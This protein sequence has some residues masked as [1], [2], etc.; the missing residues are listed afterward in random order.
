MASLPVFPTPPAP[1]IT[2]E[3]F[4][5]QA[6]PSGSLFPDLNLPPS[7][8]DRFLSDWKSSL[9]GL[10][11]S[12]AKLKLLLR[13]VSGFLSEEY[14]CPRLPLLCAWPWVLRRCCGGVK[15][16]GWRIVAAPYN[17]RGGTVF[18][19]LSDMKDLCLLHD[20][21]ICVEAQLNRPVEAVSPIFTFDSPRSLSV[22]CASVYE[23]RGFSG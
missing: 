13:V 8:L 4:S 23:V 12:L 6:T 18:S 15:F 14:R 19:R 9:V 16:R 10:K 20:S 17:V 5:L 21:I 22:R 3:C 2:M 11:S 1:S 7:K